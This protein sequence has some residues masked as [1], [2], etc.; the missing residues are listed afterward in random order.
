M[1]TNSSPALGRPLNIKR[2]NVSVKIYAGKNRVNGTNY[3]QFTL[4][5]YDGAKRVKK[6]FS[7]LEEARKEAEIATTHLANGEG[8]VL[9]LTS[10]DRASY[11]QALDTLCPLGRQLNLAVAEYAD[12]LKLLPPGG[13]FARPSPILRA[14]PTP[15]GNLVPFRNWSLSTSHPRKR[16]VKAKL[17][18]ATWP[19][20]RN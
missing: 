14:A 12:A 11:L 8:Q 16:P 3:P 5:Y 6:R 19:G 17:T 9:R 7:D 20:S 1:K 4:A 10:L 15:F 2:G 13:P 18:C